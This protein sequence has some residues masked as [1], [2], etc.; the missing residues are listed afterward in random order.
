MYA[1]RIAELQR[2]ERKLMTTYSAKS[3]TAAVSGWYP[4]AGTL[5]ILVGGVNVLQGLIALLKDD[6]FAITKGGLL[7]S[8]FAAWGTFFLVLG[9]I[10]ILV[11][12]GI[13]AVRTWAR[14]LGV[15]IVMLNTITQ[16]AFIAAF[17]IWTLASIAL[18]ITVIYALMKPLQSYGERYGY[19]E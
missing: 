16:F 8:D 13:L 6:Y 17:P 5:L 14:V 2:E 18:N 12:F 15:I 10:E 11:G 1:S 7:F 9:I 3:Q 19:I 4:F